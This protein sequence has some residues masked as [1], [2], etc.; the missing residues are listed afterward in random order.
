VTL[1]ALLERVCPP[2]PHQSFPNLLQPSSQHALQYRVCKHANTTE[3]VTDTVGGATKG[4]TDTVGGATGAGKSQQSLYAQVE[5][6]VA[7][8]Q[9][10]SGMAL[11]AV[12]LSIIIVRLFSD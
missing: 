2:T 3:G 5:E 9:T 11:A 1:S 12:F 10:A 7:E 6:F 8:N 4:V